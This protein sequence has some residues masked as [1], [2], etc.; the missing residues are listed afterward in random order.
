MA[1]TRGG[2]R[3]PEDESRPDPE[4][5]PWPQP[6]SSGRQRYLTILIC[7]D[8][9]IVARG[10]ATLLEEESSDLNV[11]AITTE[12]DE[13]LRNA[14]ELSPDVV[15]MDIYLP[16]TDPGESVRGILSASPQ[17]KVLIFNLGCGDQHLCEAL[18]A[19]AA[20]YV[21][22]DSE[23]TVIAEVVRSVA[24]GYVVLPR[25][26][27]DSWLG[28]LKAAN[29]RGL[30]DVERKILNALGRGLNNKRIAAELHLSE[31]TLRRRLVALY[32]KLGVAS[33]E[34]AIALA[35]RSSETT[36]RRRAT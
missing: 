7:D 36:D 24:S 5:F 10:V 30:D 9:P 26:V 12:R 35:A 13:A 27:V 2:Q 20:G 25:P 32:S 34:E 15:L 17:S 16:D 33:R 18:A 28:D 4:V 8:Q 14:R 31:R 3:R 19:G 1:L 22:K 21:T 23:L 6:V 29:R 11:V